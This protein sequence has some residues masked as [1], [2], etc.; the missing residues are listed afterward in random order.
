MMGWNKKIDSL[1]TLDLTGFDGYLWASDKDFPEQTVNIEKFIK[2]QNPFILEG[3]F[4]KNNTSISIKHVAGRY[5][6]NQ[7]N[8]A[9]LKEENLVMKKYVAH[10]NL[11]KK[12]CFKEIWIAEQDENCKN[13]DVLTKKAI[14]F[15]GFNREDN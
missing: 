14:A 5:I 13:I 8:L 9:E 10:S 3:N 4:Y 1:K 11:G 6:I 7:Y 12:L 15:V 2:E